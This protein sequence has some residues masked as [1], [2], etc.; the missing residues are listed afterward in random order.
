[1]PMELLF[2]NGYGVSFA[3]PDTP[4][5][6]IHPEAAAAV[7]GSGVIETGSVD[8]GLGFGLDPTASNDIS[9]NPEFL[10]DLYFSSV[11]GEDGAFL[12]EDVRFPF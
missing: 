7:A 3:D 5:A 1:M 11:A 6:S 12:S 9:T 2:G 4:V 10:N 8:H